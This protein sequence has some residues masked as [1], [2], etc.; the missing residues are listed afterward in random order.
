MAMYADDYPTDLIKRLLD[1]LIA[2]AAIVLTLPLMLL[3]SLLIKC[4]GPGPI[5]YRQERVG[6]W[7]RTFALYKFRS[8]R[9]DAEGNPAW[10]AGRDSGVTRVGRF[11]CCTRIEELPQLLNVLRGEM[12][13]VGPRPDDLD[14]VKTLSAA[15]P[16]Y[17]E[18]HYVKPGIIG[19]AQL[20]TAHGVSIE[21]VREE[22]GYDLYY[23]KNHSLLLDVRI[24][25]STVWAIFFEEGFT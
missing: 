23:V 19:W 4:D 22:L 1:L 13:I 5:L 18:R 8:M 6:L 15:I 20:Y 24:L 7:G 25:I 14:I 17:T 10:V 21:E 2:S 12:S 3:V 9:P 16:S 11:I